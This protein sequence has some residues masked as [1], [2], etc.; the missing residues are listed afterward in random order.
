MSERSLEGA[1]LIV[2]GGGRGIGRAI[3]LAAAAAGARV[4][5]NDLGCD[6]DGEGADPSVAE[7]VV[8]EIRAAGGVAV[9]DTSDV[10]ASGA[11]A[12]LVARSSEAG[13]LSAIYHCAGVSLERSVLKMDEAILDRMLRVHVRASFELVRAG[14][15][16]ML[17]HKDGGSIVLCAGPS[18][19][20]AA[21]GASASGAG[22]AA[23]V[24][25]C[26]SAALELR[27]H[28]VRVNV[29][30][31]TAK[32]RVN[33]GLPTFQGV[34]DGSLSPEHVAAVAVFLGSDAAQDISGEV[35]GVAGARAYAIRARE[36]TGVFSEGGPF[37]A[38][39]LQ[40]VW[41]EIV[42]G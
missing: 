10:A 32:T 7:S 1:N 25:L 30:A 17:A 3:A 15:E 36:T 23:V 27:R 24:A 31:P 34:G 19:F 9:S 28:R 4:M 29:L 16:A 42:R 20:F 39:A 14:A 13:P 18:A 37:R 11:A 35:I 26:R 8:A 40:Q 6:V 22:N 41:P 5:V 38:D 2:T 12:A 21:R 33:E